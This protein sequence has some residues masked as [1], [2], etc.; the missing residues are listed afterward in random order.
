MWQRLTVGY[1]IRSHT[2]KSNLQSIRLSNPLLNTGAPAAH[3]LTPLNAA[4]F[5][6][7]HGSRRTIAQDPHL[8]TEKFAAAILLKILRTGIS[9]CCS[10][11]QVQGSAKSP[12][13]VTLFRNRQK[14]QSNVPVTTLFHNRQKTKAMFRSRP[15]SITGK[16]Q[17]NVPIKSIW[18]TVRT[19]ANATTTD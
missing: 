1:R 12:I 9:P 3:C 17:S 2:R 8:N 11:L 13:S 16:N 6:T 19:I 4:W 18:F 10:G 15:Y 7:W 14:N 5:P